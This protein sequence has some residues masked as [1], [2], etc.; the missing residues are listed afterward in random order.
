VAGA[1]RLS[2]R[3]EPCTGAL[4][5]KRSPRG[6]TLAVLTSGW[7]VHTPPARADRDLSGDGVGGNR[8]EPGI[9]IRAY[10]KLCRTC[11]RLPCRIGRAPAELADAGFER[12]KGIV[13]ADGKEYLRGFWQ[14]ATK[15]HLA[16]SASHHGLA[17][18]RT[19]ER[20]S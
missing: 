8:F 15:S 6:A 16:T 1:D 2:R 11:V 7:V 19:L 14:P 20:C 13:E 10:D 18:R 12:I 5:D 9:D 3:R 17:T 4:Y